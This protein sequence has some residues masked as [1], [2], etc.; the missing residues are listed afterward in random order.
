M[1][2]SDS[3]VTLRFSGNAST[4]VTTPTD[5]RIAEALLSERC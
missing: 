1:R 5:L 2:R 4:T 3:R